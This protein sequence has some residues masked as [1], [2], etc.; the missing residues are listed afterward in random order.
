M[1]AIETTSYLRDRLD[2]ARRKIE[3]ITWRLTAD[4]KG[5][6]DDFRNTD[7]IVHPAFSQYEPQPYPGKI[8]LLQ[9]SEWPKSPYFD[10]KLGWEDLAQTID[11]HRIIADHAYLFDEPNVGAVANALN[12]YMEN[13]AKIE[14]DAGFAKPSPERKS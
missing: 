1:D 8:V 5:H 7:S 13:S 4:R 14:V 6:T 10:F 3:R 11:F 9:S 12:A 2:E